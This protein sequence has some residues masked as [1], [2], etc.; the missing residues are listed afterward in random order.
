MLHFA[1]RNGFYFETG[2]ACTSIDVKE[3]EEEQQQEE[4]ILLPV[5]C[6]QELRVLKILQ[7]WYA[8]AAHR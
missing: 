5:L 2:G 3:C 6:G 8:T 4:I 1:N 7:N